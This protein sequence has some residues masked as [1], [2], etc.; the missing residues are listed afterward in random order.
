MG[1]DSDTAL[2]AT[3]DGV[4]EGEIARGWETPRGPLGGYVMAIVLRAFELAVDDRERQARSVTMH[5]L[6]VPRQGPVGSARASSGR[7]GP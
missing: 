7:G 6:R 2:R 5:F 3:G 1:F 4:W